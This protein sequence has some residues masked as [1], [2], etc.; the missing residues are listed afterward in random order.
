MKSIYLTLTC[1]LLA[2]IVVSTCI[3]IEILNYE[4]GQILP[5]D[6]PENTNPKWR[7]AA[8]KT[9][10]SAAERQLLLTRVAGGDGDMSQYF[11]AEGAVLAN[12]SWSPSEL[13]YISYE[14]EAS[15]LNGEL[16]SLVSG[17]GLLQYILA[18]LLL[19][20]SIV[21]IIKA[22]KAVF[23]FVG[24]IS[25]PIACVAIYFMFY[26]EYFTSLGW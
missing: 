23:R 10:R 5:R 13:Q 26:R 2:V 19:V 20:V 6:L 24:V 11:D 1:A 12:V 4:C 8:M 7:V 15:R 16:K 14:V 9:T 21:L 25:A 17:M 3:R 22:D 18:P